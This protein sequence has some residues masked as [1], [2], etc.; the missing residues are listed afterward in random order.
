MKGSHRKVKCT[1]MHLLVASS[2]NNKQICFMSRIRLTKILKFSL[3]FFLFLKL[4]QIIQRELKVASTIIGRL[5]LA[6]VR[7]LF[8][9]YQFPDEIDSPPARDQREILLLIPD[10]HLRPLFAFLLPAIGKF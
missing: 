2:H 10:A 6:T 9:P 8:L 4:I 3:L 5:N 1:V 7:C